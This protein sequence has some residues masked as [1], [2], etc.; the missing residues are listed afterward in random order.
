MYKPLKLKNGKTVMVKLTPRQV[1]IDKR[2][3]YY[4]WEYVD[5]EKKFYQIKMSQEEKT[6]YILANYF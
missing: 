5:K 1:R 3:G 4:Y 2:T 6:Q